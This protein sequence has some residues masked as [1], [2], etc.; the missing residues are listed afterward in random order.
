MTTCTL[1]TPITQTTKVTI[2]NHL[3]LLQHAPGME[4][5]LKLSLVLQGAPSFFVA[6]WQM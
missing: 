2:E 6:T 5:S 1:V 3:G 4:D